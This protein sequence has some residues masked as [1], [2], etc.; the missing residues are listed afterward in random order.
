MAS[1]LEIYVNILKALAQRGPLNAS[2][3]IDENISENNFKG[4]MAFLIRQGLIEAQIVGENN[5]VYAN[6]ARG[7]SVIKFFTQL[8]K[9]LTAVEEGNISTINY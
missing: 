2:N 8:D 4:S 9:T 1:K 5:V 6:T 7:T 3:L